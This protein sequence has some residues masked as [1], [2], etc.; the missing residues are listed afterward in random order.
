MPIRKAPVSR[1]RKRGP[2]AP[3]A[4]EGERPRPSEFR[5]VEVNGRNREAFVR[6]IGPV[7]EHSPW[8]AKRAWPK[9]PFTSLRALHGALCETVLAASE[10]E[11]LDLIRAHP[12]LAGRAALTGS[13][14]PSST[15]EQ[16]SAGLDKL[17]PDEIT[18]FRQLNQAYR[19]KF[20]FPFVICARLNKKDA[21]LTGF[22][23]RLEHSRPE[24]IR[25]ALEE[26]FKIASL[27]L[28]DAVAGNF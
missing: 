4:R 27:R 3:R 26:I 1:P 11:K 6:V 5:L 19:A 9:R 8:I 25:T 23:V 18:A 28:Q 14:T 10:R 21:I 13:L 15:Q 20:G 16:T 22:R 2:S 24:E 7:F 12:D 17:T